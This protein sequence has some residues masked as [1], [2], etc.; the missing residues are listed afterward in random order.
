MG[1][2]ITEESLD[3]NAL[4]AET[5]D[6]S[7]GGLVVFYGAVRD[8]NDGREVDGMTYEAHVSM[9]EKVIREI[10]GEM[11]ACFAI[12]TCRIQHR[13]GPL[14]LGEVSVIVVANSPHRDAAFQAARYGID[15][16]KQRVPIWKEEH[17]IG[18]QSKYLDGVPLV[19]DE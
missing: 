6:V 17:Y 16:V 5:A 9:A 12:K 15:E 2:W 13:I 18:G 14:A 3:A 4:L 7:C 11:L 10:E 19:K 8:S 1:R